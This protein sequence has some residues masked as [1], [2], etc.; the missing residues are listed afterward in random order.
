MLNQR[1]VLENED[2][3]SSHKEKIVYNNL[4]QYELN[5]QYNNATYYSIKRGDNLTTKEYIELYSDL[6]DNILTSKYIKETDICYGSHVM[7]RIDL[8]KPNEVNTTHKLIIW[9]HG[10]NWGNVQVSTKEIN[11]FVANGPLEKGY[12]F[13]SIEYPF[14]GKGAILKNKLID[15]S[16]NSSLSDIVL[17]VH[18]AV[19]FIIDY[20]KT[21]LTIKKENIYLCGHSAGA[22]LACLEILKENKIKK[23]IFVSMISDLE[24]ISVSYLNDT[25]NLTENEINNLSP[26]KHVNLNN[27]P[28]DCQLLILNGSI[29]TSEF[30]RQSYNFY[31]ICMK[32]DINCTHIE[33][34]GHGHLSILLELANKDGLILKYLDKLT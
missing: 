24:P 26:I 30:K 14:N 16:G 5:K 11:A 28:K 10:G 19:D 33:L 8:F 29:E 20:A 1:N 15:N 4:T 12:H 6:S 23:G 7:N 13:A 9:L 2:N 21:N 3:I 32:Y 31:D 25:L 27:V 22:H 17:S 18:S 34:D